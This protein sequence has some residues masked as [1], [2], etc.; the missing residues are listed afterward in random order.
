MSVSQFTFTL[1]KYTAEHHIR[2]EYF[3]KRININ[4]LY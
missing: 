2:G 4:L 1:R 3:T